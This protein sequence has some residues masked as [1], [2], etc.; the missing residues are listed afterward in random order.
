MALGADGVISV[1]ANEAPRLVSEMISAASSGDAKRAREIHYKLLPLMRANFMETNP[2]PVKTAMALMGHCG[3][4]LRPPLGPL[5]EQ[6]LE[7][8]QLVLAGSGLDEKKP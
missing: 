2:V 7:R 6:S 3:P 5:S 4:G 8:L 1:V